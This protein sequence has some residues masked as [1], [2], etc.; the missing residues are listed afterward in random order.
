[1]QAE[2]G[3]VVLLP[4]RR[5]IPRRLHRPRAAP[6]A[7]T[8]RSLL[9]MTDPAELAAAAVRAGD[10]AA[11]QATLESEPGLARVRLG[12]DDT[13]RT[14][15]HVATDWPGHPPN[16]AITISVLARA[17]ADVDAPFHGEHAETPLHWAASSDDV[18]AIDALL[19]A[20]ANID[21]SGGSVG[22]GTGTPLFDATVFGQWAAARR[23]IERGASTGGWEEAA[24]GLTG[25]LGARLRG[26]SVTQEQL[27]DWF[28]AACHGGSRPT[29]ELLVATGADPSRAAAWDG[30]TP[31]DAAIRSAAERTPGAAD[32]ADWLRERAAAQA[33]IPSDPPA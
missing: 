11:L 24:L 1:M 10:V 26:G 30:L 29:A 16:V 14:L 25:P 28:W 32:V 4:G 13:G 2:E 33:A 9:V 17:G 22:D 21:A 27:D 12:G 8:S 15:L 6:I 7:T 18:A 3:L 5:L 23:L 31:L 20:G 19:D